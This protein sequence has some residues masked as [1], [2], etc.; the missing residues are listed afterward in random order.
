MKKLSFK[1][2]DLKVDELLQRNELKTI[3]GA[4]GPAG[5]CSVSSTCSTGCAQEVYLGSWPNVF[6]STCCQPPY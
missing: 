6:C 4:G 3:V 2:L 1:N 5:S